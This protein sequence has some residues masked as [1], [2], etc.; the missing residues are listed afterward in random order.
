MCMYV[1]IMMCILVHGDT[2]RRE[3]FSDCAVLDANTT[4]S[5]VHALG[6]QMGL[7]DLSVCRVDAHYNVFCTYNYVVGCIQVHQGHEAGGPEREPGRCLNA[8]R[9]HS[10]TFTLTFL[11]AL[12]DILKG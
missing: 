11:R 1:Y 4:V 7:D 9:D 2:M 3:P 8:S 12:K 6:A 5:R 10:V